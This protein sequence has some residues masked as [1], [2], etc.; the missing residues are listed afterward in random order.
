M[1]ADTPVFLRDATWNDLI[2]AMNRDVALRGW[3]GVQPCM[4]S[5]KV[6][7]HTLADRLGGAFNI[8]PEKWRASMQLD[9]GSG[10]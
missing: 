5:G 8:W 4:A 2:K 3:L 10:A 1:Q 9:N 7:E 6:E